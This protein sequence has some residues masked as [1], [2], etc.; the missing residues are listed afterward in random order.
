MITKRIIAGK[1]KNQSIN[2]PS[3]QNTRSTK[4][5]IKESLFNSL[6]FDVVDEIFVEVFG[7]SGSIG[8]EALSRGASH[9][10][11]FEKDKEAF[12]ILKQNCIKIAKNDTTCIDGDSFKEFPKLLK[13][14]KQKTFFYFD[15]P[16]ST[17]DGMKDIYQST[18]KLIEIIPKELSHLVI[19]EHIS[20]QAMP[21]AIGEYR[22]KKSKKF[23]K[24]RLTYYA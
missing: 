3:L 8:L 18:I 4:S 6:Q 12:A 5:I 1:Y 10:Y 15:P 17:R 14:L 13:R 2:L 19:I 11:F 7:G 24:S 9:A 16:F 20:S 22:A 21:E 23:G